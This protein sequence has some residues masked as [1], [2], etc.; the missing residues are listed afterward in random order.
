MTVADV[1]VVVIV[2]HVTITVKG[3]IENWSTSDFTSTFKW[4]IKGILPSGKHNIP[5]FSS[6]DLRD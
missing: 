6:P 1:A 3:E 5:F 2:Q 4:I